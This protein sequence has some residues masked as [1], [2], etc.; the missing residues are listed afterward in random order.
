MTYVIGVN[1]LG[2][3]AILCDNRITYTDGSGSNIALKSGEL[4]PGCIYGYSAD[5]VEVARDF[6]LAAKYHV[7][8]SGTVSELWSAF[9]SFVNNYVFSLS[10][11]DVFEV[12][13]STRATGTPLF[14][15]L[16]PATKLVR[17]DKELIT[18]GS[19]KSILDFLVFREIAKYLKQFDELFLKENEN[20]YR[21][22]LPG[23][24][25][26]FF[27]TQLAQ[28]VF[29]NKL[30]ENGI[31]GVF[32]FIGQTEDYEFKQAP[33]LYLLC[34]LDEQN[35]K[36]NF[37]EFRVS[38][39]YHWLVLN[40]VDRLNHPPKFDCE[41]ENF[42]FLDESALPINETYKTYDPNI[43]ADEFHRNIDSVQNSLPL[44]YFCGIGYR[45]PL[46]NP[47]F[48]FLIGSGAGNALNGE[49]LSA[50]LSQCLG[51]LGN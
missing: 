27:L 41:Q 9:T 37:S 1:H 31:G 33:S 45:N 5:N 36:I 42:A 19:G 46:V 44:F 49:N 17:V 48:G 50:T 47:K 15:R 35:K 4:F 29:R 26:A 2:I 7:G 39:V 24:L 14:F 32:H 43:L 18:I 21:T 22:E 3:N 10:D 11:N 30:E 28:G 40:V 12:I 51:L 34:E 20:K 16:N 38:Y 6:I 23:Y 8:V 13:I 25:L